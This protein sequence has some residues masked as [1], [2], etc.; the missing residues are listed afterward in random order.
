VGAYAEG[1]PDVL[2]VAAG[3]GG[4]VIAAAAV[5]ASMGIAPAETMVATLAWER[6]IVDPLPGPRLSVEFDELEP[7][8]VTTFEFGSQTRARAPAGSSLPRLRTE[9]GVRIALLE[10]H[11]GAHGLRRQLQ[12]I[13]AACEARSLI[14]VDV[15]GDAVADGTEAH[16]LSPL[17]DA[18]VVAGATGLLVDATLVVAGPGLD[19]ELSEAQVYQRMATLKADQLP[20]LSS[21]VASRLMRVL[22]WH[23]SE[24]TA[25]LAAAVRGIR[26][27]AEVRDSGYQVPISDTSPTMWSMSLEAA[28]RR[29]VARVL[30]ASSSIEDADRLVTALVGRS[31]L[32]YERSKS[33]LMSA[34]SRGEGAALGDAELERAFQCLQSAA[35]KRGTDYLTSRRIAESLTTPADLDR[36]RAWLSRQHGDQYVPPLWKVKPAA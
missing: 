5:A 9:L 23:P 2:F 20:A 1:V 26:G 14:V 35:K 10:A 21:E 7:V 32:A 6:L 16:L 19:G 18:L 17:A 3:G 12:E 36:I 22:E 31:E 8:G 33:A 28:A 27:V 15:G 29:G 25:L 11:A 30:L 24:A 4:D 13:A 34:P